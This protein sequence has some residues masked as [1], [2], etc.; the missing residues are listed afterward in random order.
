[1]ARQVAKYVPAKEAGVLRD[2]REKRAWKISDANAAVFQPAVRDGR[3]VIV[4]SSALVFF[5][6]RGFDQAARVQ[7]F[8][9]A[10]GPPN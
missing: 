7:K 6:V 8:R 9:L 4:A 3:S 10:E 5:S 2:Q 1:M